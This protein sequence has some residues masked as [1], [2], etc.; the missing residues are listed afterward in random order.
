M[1][2][3]E[4]E[5]S[6]CEE[7]AGRSS[8]LG[9]LNTM[10]WY[11]LHTRHNHERAVYQ[12][13]LGKVFEPYLPLVRLVR[14]SRRENRPAYAPLFQREVFVRC[15]LDTY[16]HLELV[17][18]PGVIAL[19]RN[20]RG[21]PLTVPDEEIRT[22]RLLCSAEVPLEEFS[23]EPRGERMRVL[24]GGLRGIT[25][26]VPEGSSGTLVIPIRTLGKN[27]AVRMSRAE[28]LPCS[29]FVERVSTGCSTL[30]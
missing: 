23:H 8:R 24:Q 19:A 1:R 13:L 3:R 27:V 21:L 22:L 2:V 9:R 11:A 25:G 6:A 7:T 12:R 18:T 29:N 20:S 14:T 26:I 17:T 15:N 10:E 30:I 16:T 28:M 4:A 5:G